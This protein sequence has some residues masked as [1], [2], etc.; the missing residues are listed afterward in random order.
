MEVTLL[1][2]ASRARRVGEIA[3]RRPTDP[4]TGIT[5]FVGGRKAQ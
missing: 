4:T 2:I 3:R 5:Q 1:A